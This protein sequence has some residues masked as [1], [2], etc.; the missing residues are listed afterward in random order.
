MAK[1]KSAT[2]ATNAASKA[3]TGLARWVTTDHTG[4]AKLLANLPPMGFIDTLSMI[5]VT[6][7]CSLLGAAASGA[8]LYLLIT[9][10]IPA[11]LSF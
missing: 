9:Y 10:G 2:Y 5:L 3:I 11:L 6:A 1:R 7:L 4:T 8:L